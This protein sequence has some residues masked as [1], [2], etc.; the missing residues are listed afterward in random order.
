MVNKLSVPDLYKINPDLVLEL[1]DRDDL[2]GN[3]ANSRGL[4]VGAHP[5]LLIGLD[6]ALFDPFADAGGRS[7]A[8]H[9]PAYQS[10]KGANYGSGSGADSFASSWAV[11][12]NGQIALDSGITMFDPGLAGGGASTSFNS[13]LFAVGSTLDDSRAGAGG[14]LTTYRAGARN[15][16]GYNIKIEFKGTGWTRDLQTAFTHAAD[17]FTTVITADLPG[18]NAFALGGGFV[19]DLYIKA[20]V[21]AIDG[22]GGIL[23]QA[24]PSATWTQTQLTA[25]GRM[26]FDVADATSFYQLGLWDDI[27]THEMMHVLGFGSLWNFGNHHLVQNNA[28]GQPAY[29][30]GPNALAAYQADTVFG[31]P[32]ALYIPVETNGGAG[33]AGAHWDDDTLTNELMT[34]YIGKPGD[35]YAPNVLSQ[36]SVMSLAD[37]GY[38]VGNY[39]PYTD[40]PAP[41]V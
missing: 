6:G 38:T 2:T 36:F 12:D 26:Q 31:D 19:D 39:Q 40:L 37:L 3:S 15:G 4:D 34:G 11:S 22:T 9:A 13:S 10:P 8:S 35:S 25:T 21:S 1:G 5:G 14:V 33:T 41:L 24:G 29:Y 27:V 30:T 28:S 23:G 20:E 32:N 18:S 7:A 16:S 17:Y